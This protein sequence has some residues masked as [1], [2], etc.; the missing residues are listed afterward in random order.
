M[1]VCCS[2]GP[3]NTGY[4]VV[5]AARNVSLNYKLLL[6]CCRD[7]GFPWDTETILIT[8][9]LLMNVCCVPA[10]AGT[11]GWWK[12]FSSST[13]YKKVL[14][15]FIT[16]WLARICREPRSV[17]S[18]LQIKITSE[19]C[20]YCYSKCPFSFCQGK[21]SRVPQGSGCLL[22]P[23]WDWRGSI[24]TSIFLCMMKGAMRQCN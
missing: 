12:G 21:N 9:L 15:L 13:V 7:F 19:L 1:H 4:G 6:S 10:C 22:H 5:G 23:C 17:F 18:S 2:L 24:F 14:K 16:D 8:V 11:K 20:F 3:F